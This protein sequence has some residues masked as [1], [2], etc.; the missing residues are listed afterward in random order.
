MESSTRPRL[1]PLPAGVFE[2]TRIPV[3]G[4]IVARQ[5]GSLLLI[6]GAAEAGAGLARRIS[7]DH[8]RTWTPP[9]PIT[10]ERM[11][12]ASGCGL[13]RLASGRLALYHGAPKTGWWLSTS[14]DDGATWTLA[15]RITDY[16]MYIPMYHSLIQLA[17]G[18]LLLAGYWQTDEPALGAER[19]APSGWGW[20]QGRT[21]FMEGHRGP[22]VGFC[23]TYH[24]DDEGRTWKQGPS[25]LVW[26]IFGWFDER[27]DLN[28]AGGVIDLYEPTAA[29]TRDGRVLLM[30]RS[31][32]GRLVQSWS[33]DSGLTWYP[34]EPT[35]LASSQSPPLLIRIPRT[36]DLLCVWN[37]VSGAE[38]R[39]GFLR[40]RL[41]SAI[42]TDDGS[43]WGHFQTL[44][45]QP[46]MENVA[47]I[48]PEF[49][50]PRHLV[51]R[52]P[53]SHL[54]D[55]FAMFTYPNVDL[56]GDRVFVRYLRAWARPVEG[57]EAPPVDD[58]A[59]RMWPRHEDREAEM[60]FETVLRIY[61]LEWFYS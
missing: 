47:R 39:R 42:S 21:L 25:D 6:H 52:S 35:E 27:G 32:I 57:R 10:G 49:P 24:S 22:C 38:I 60:Q 17:N 46:G 61:P 33:R 12:G 28:G 9:E 34:A 19:M 13:I 56:V 16:P 45:L 14:D 41:S 31:K 5:D 51:G 55:D 48:A 40:G 1:Q 50:M 54:P 7:L 30:A 23:F 36:G 43:T 11:A 4:G 26:G 2:S 44:E 18:R 20:W 15:G 8:G 53:F 3:E 29:E 37:Q 58:G 59:P